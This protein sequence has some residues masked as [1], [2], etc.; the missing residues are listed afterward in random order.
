MQGYGVYPIYKPGSSPFTVYFYIKFDKPFHCYGVWID[1]NIMSGARDGHGKKTGVYGGYCTLEGEPIQVKV[2]I[3][4]ISIE[5]AQYNLVKEIPDWN[6][7]EC[8]DKNKKP[9][10]SC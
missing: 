2:G 1:N 7:D 10:M 6:F 3:S 4:Y 5:Q 8:K 9:G